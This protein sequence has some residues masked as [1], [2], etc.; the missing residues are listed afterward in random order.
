M[1]VLHTIIRLPLLPF[2]DQGTAQLK[3]WTARIGFGCYFSYSEKSLRV[4]GDQHPLLKGE[5]VYSSSV[6]NVQVVFVSRFALWL[7]STARDAVSCVN[8]HL[9]LSLLHALMA[10]TTNS[11]KITVF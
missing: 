9:K 7:D 5:K 2:V 10:S 11:F 4:L 1:L 6:Q 3:I 8:P